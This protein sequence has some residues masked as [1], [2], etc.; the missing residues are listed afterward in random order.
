[1]GWVHTISSGLAQFSCE[2]LPLF[3]GKKVGLILGS[4]CEDDFL[5]GQLPLFAMIDDSYTYASLHTPIL[6]DAI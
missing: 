2:F 1:M 4:A 5:L 3:F 6:A